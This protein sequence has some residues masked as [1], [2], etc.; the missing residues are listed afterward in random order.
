VPAYLLPIIAHDTTALSSAVISRHV[1]C[2]GLEIGSEKGIDCVG[3]FSRRVFDE[4]IRCAFFEYD[5]VDIGSDILG[6]RGRRLTHAS[7]GL[8]N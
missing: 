2:I 6:Q 3:F 8:T 4:G 5:V 7:V 1:R